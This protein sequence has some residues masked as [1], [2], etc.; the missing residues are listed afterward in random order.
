MKSLGHLICGLLVLSTNFAIAQEAD[1]QE[2]E[3]A[4][5]NKM[6]QTLF[7]GDFQLALQLS[8][9]PG[10]K[11]DAG[12]YHTFRGLAFAGQ[13]NWA[14]A[15]GEFR[16]ATQLSP[17]HFPGF[18]ELAE[19]FYQLRKFKEARTYYAKAARIQK[20]DPICLYKILLCYL[21]EGK[22]KEAKRWLDKALPLTDKNPS[23]QYANAAWNFH[24]GNGEAAY[25][26]IHSAYTLFPEN[27]QHA[28][29][30]PLIN[31]GWIRQEDI[32]P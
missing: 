26:F 1:A 19:T 20:R 8:E 4:H 15:L 22:E 23:Y 6:R 16:L 28:F 3:P 17:D 11:Q 21:K 12:P 2:V 31:E 14:S 30:Q 29:L 24:S 32:H 9:E 25:Y 7:T 5:E 13:K 18:F 27:M 10:F